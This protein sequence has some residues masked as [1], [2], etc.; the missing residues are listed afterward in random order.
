[1]CKKLGHGSSYGGKAATLAEQ[2]RIPVNLVTDF[3]RKFFETFQAHLQWQAWVDETLR[4]RGHLVSLMGRKRWFFGR[5]NDPATLREAIAYDPQSSLRDIVSTALLRIWRK[6]YVI[7]A[8]D[9][10]DALTFMYPEKLEST[11]IPQIMKDLIVEVPLAH[12]RVL[13]I[14][15]DC[16]VG[17]NKGKYHP[18]KNPNG[19]KAYHGHD[20]RTRQETLGLL[21]RVIRKTN[22]GT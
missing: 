15:Y 14:P 9:D 20:D 7:I 18:E 16:E 17:W 8:M 21:D 10:H 22:S 11:I 3:Q 6:N 19:L 4:K 5:R 12:D 13:R 1:M 2:A